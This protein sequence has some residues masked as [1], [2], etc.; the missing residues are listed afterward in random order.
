[1]KTKMKTIA[2]LILLLIPTIFY[3]QT[4]T[5]KVMDNAATV[6][7]ANITVTNNDEIITGTITDDNGL[8]TLKIVP[9]NYILTISFIGY[10]NVEKA[11]SVEKD[12]DLGT[13][14]LQ[15]DAESLN[16][17]VLKVEKRSIERKIDR[18]VFNVEQS[19]AATG[20]NGLDVL[21]ITPGVQVQN[22]VVEILGKGATQILINGRISPLQGDELASFLSGISASDIQKIEVI[23]NP[24]AKY[25]ASGNGGLINIILKKGVQD[26]WKNSTTISYNQNRYNFTTISNNFF[27][28]KRD[29]S[30]SGSLN[31]TKGSFENAEG[32]LIDYPT[33]NW[34]IDVDSEIGKDQF[35]GHFL[36]DYALSPKTTF[37]LQ[38]LGNLTKPTIEGTTTSKIFDNDNNLQK[39]LINQGD[40]IVDNKNHSLNFHAITQ[41][42]SIGKSISF[43]VDY[44]TFNSENS[45]DY[46]TEEFD[47]FD[48]SQG[49][50]DAAL[51]IANQE[52]ENF[53]SK[54]D[55]DFMLGKI[56]L[57]YGIKASFTN[58]KSDVLYYKTL[59]GSAI[60]DQNRS[61]EFKYAENVL[62]GYISGNAN[63][64]EKLKVQFGLRLEDT[65]TKGIN[66]EMDQ[67]TI[68]KY[69]KLFPTLY[70]AYAQND[71]S[72]FRFSYGK[73][74]SRPN[75]RNLNPFRFY[76]NTNSYSVGNPFLQPSFSD[77]FEFSHLYKKKLNS[78]I[79]LNITKD[80]SGTVFTSDA[81]NQNQIITREN[82]YNQYNYGITE[83]FSFNKLK[84]F[85]SE[86]SINVLGYYTKFTKNFGTTPKNGLQLYVTSNNTFSLS[87]KTKLQ[88][89]SYYSSQHNRG[90]FSV[91]EMFDLSFGVQHN[92]KENLKMSLLFSDIFN[93]ASLKDYISTVNGIEQNYSQDLSSRNL[94]ISL[95]YDFGNKKVNVKNRNFGNDDEQKRS[96]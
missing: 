53:S 72:N 82:Y 33:N 83:S 3:A 46:F 9:G 93:T 78:S 25:E 5:G 75:F 35:S 10:T 23:T 24:S 26:S 34:D 94:R 45:R 62:A 60:L 86:N 64:S 6:P 13:I 59:S 42:D 31:A 66:A 49:I 41:L 1:M 2:F 11:I 44:F 16:E 27:Y 63:I 7:F 89:N 18:L 4:I 29:I 47:V 85:K 57:S 65:K 96:N 39:T 90:L 22:G 79:F 52:I 77:N 84:W 95:S 37:G 87:E 36:V 67:E 40:N 28:N 48:V 74:I 73:R 55:V 91:G 80:G 20:G 70:F 17:I 14:I 12:I 8:F 54:I 88:L 30:F 69:T 92:F 68:N 51:N 61:N 21:K 43:D 81:E 19:I 76:I 38:Y 32:I 71:D 58:T 15:E 56:N 50:N